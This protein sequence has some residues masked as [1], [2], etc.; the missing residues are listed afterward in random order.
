[1]LIVD[2]WMSDLG[3][4]LQAEERS[5][6]PNAIEMDNNVER[7]GMATSLTFTDVR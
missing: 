2:Y 6:L 5:V 7:H 3:A 1:M 4:I